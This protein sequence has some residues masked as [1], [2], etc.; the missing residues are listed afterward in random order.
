MNKYLAL[1]LLLLIGCTEPPI[2]EP[3]LDTE[4]RGVDLSF[5]PEIK[6]RN[7]I[8]T[9]QEMQEEDMLLTL[10]KAGVNVIRL[11][12]WKKPSHPTSN[13]D[14]VKQLSNQ[15]KQ[16]GMKVMLTVH[17]SDT[18]ADPGN[19]RKPQEWENANFSQLKDSVY[20]YTTK[21]IQE[22]QPE[23]I[24]IGNEINNGFLWTEG[25]YNYPT[26]LKELLERGIKAVRDHRTSTKII[27]HFAGYDQ[28]DARLAQLQTLDYD[29][30]GISYY[31]FWHGKS[32]EELKKN[33]IALS[34]KYNKQI[35][36]AETSYPFTFL[37]NDWTHNVIGNES[38][39]LPEFPATPEGQQM[40][41]QNIKT[42][43]KAVPKGVGFCYWGAEWISYK[44]N[45]ATDASS[46]ENQSL[47][48]FNNKA[49][50]ALQ[51]FAK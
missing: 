9:N 21:I 32:L 42:L 38:Q 22:I 49:L 43:M 8:L 25:S 7:I 12:I 16:M 6:E 10:K 23:Y 31:P 24:Q 3:P 17:Y 36:I 37:W 15:I 28:T 45:Q 4:I 5:Y 26:Q 20:L 40:Y 27:L 46:W 1:L 47:W 29:L 30:L 41:L 48:D 2:P 11:R 44:G 33:L 51:A 35:F 13:F 18:W 50:P 39:I 19:Q 14:T 34:T